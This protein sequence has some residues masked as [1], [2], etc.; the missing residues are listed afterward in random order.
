MRRSPGC[1]MPCRYGIRLSLSGYADHT[2]A[3][4]ARKTSFGVK[5]PVCMLLRVMFSPGYMD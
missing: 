1:A 3:V 4:T 5:Q 2:A